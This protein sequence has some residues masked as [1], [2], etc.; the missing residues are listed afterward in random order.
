MTAATWVLAIA[1]C[2]LAL[3]GGTA[4]LKWMQSLRVGRTKRELEALRREVTLL[5]H[6]IWMDVSRAAQGNPAQGDEKV[7][8]MLAL[9]GWQ[10]DMSLAEQA[11]Y[12]RLRRP[13]G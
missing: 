9:D 13:R 2:A 5:H 10:P 8:K 1:T 4:L 11:G 7:K 12:F 3:E 6:A